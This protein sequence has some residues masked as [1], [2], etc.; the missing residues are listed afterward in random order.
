MRLRSLFLALWCLLFTSAL[1][2]A[3]PFPEATQLNDTEF[4]VG[5]SVLRTARYQS[6]FIFLEP[7]SVPPGAPRVPNES[8]GTEVQFPTQAGDSLNFNLLGA[9][10]RVEVFDAEGRR[11]T[12]VIFDDPD[13]FQN[14]LAFV[15]EQSG[16]YT[17]VFSLIEEEQREP[18]FGFVVIDTNSVQEDQVDRNTPQ[19]A[20]RVENF[21]EFSDRTRAVQVS[22]SVG[23][24]RSTFLNLNDLDE[25]G[26]FDL[27]TLDWQLNERFDVLASNAIPHIE[28]TLDTSEVR[29]LSFEVP[30]GSDRVIVDIDSFGETVSPLV[31]LQPN[32]SEGLPLVALS[33]NRNEDL[34]ESE[35]RE[36]D[37][38]IDSADPVV[39]L[40][41]SSDLVPNSGFIVEPGRYVID[42]QAPGS[43]GESASSSFISVSVSVDGHETSN[44]PE[45]LADVYSFDL[46]SDESATLLL[47]S[48][49]E[50]RLI[51]EEGNTLVEAVPSE[52]SEQELTIAP[53]SRNRRIFVELR[54]D[55][56]DFY[57]LD[58]LLSSDEPRYQGPR[59]SLAKVSGASPSYRERSFVLR[60]RYAD[61]PGLRRFSYQ[62]GALAGAP[63]A[64]DLGKGVDGIVTAR[65]TDALGNR[66]ANERSFRQRRDLQL[67]FTPETTGVYTL[68]VDLSE[69][70]GATDELVIAGAVSSAVEP[71]EFLQRGSSDVE[72]SIDLNNQFRPLTDRSSTLSVRG[73]IGLPTAPPIEREA[74]DAI[75]LAQFI[76][77]TQFSRQFN[78]EIRDS[79]SVPHVTI[80]GT[81]DGSRDYFSFNVP[82]GGARLIIDVDASEGFDPIVRV[83]DPDRRLIFT[84]TRTTFNDAEA[85]VSDFDHPF[86][87]RTLVQRGVYT[88]EVANDAFFDGDDIPDGASYR[89][90]ISVSGVRSTGSADD[91]SDVYAVDLETGDLLN[92]YIDSG[93]AD[94]TF[95]D[96][97]GVQLMSQDFENTGSNLRGKGLER[98]TQSG[99]YYVKVTSPQGTR[100][101]LL[102]LQD[103]RISEVDSQALNGKI[104]VNETLLTTAPPASAG[105]VNAYTLE[106]SAGQSVEVE[107]FAERSGTVQFEL[108]GNDGTLISGRDTTFGG[109]EFI[110]LSPVE[111]T[112]YQLSI[113]SCDRDAITTVIETRLAPLPF[114]LIGLDRLRTPFEDETIQLSVPGL[115]EADLAGLTLTI[116][117]DGTE[118]LVVPATLEPI[119][120]RFL[121]GGT[122]EVSV[123]LEGSRLFA[124]SERTFQV[125]VLPL[126][127]LT[128]LISSVTEGDGSS[129]RFRIQRQGNLQE[130]L[131]VVYSASDLIGNCEIEFSLSSPT[132]DGRFSVTIPAGQEQVT[133][134]WRPCSDDL[135]TP[136]GN[137][138]TLT[139]EESPSYAL[140]ATQQL[141]FTILEDD[142]SP[143]AAD[144][145]YTVLQGETLRVDLVEDG[146]LN[147]A[148]DQD[149]SG[150]D[151]FLS[152]FSNRDEQRLRL[153]NDVAEIFVDA[154]GTF[155]FLPND[156]AFTGEI[157]FPYSVSDGTNTSAIRMVT[158]EV[159]P[160]ALLGFTFEGPP[161]PVIK[162]G[163]LHRIGTGSLDVLEGSTPGPVLLVAEVE[164][165]PRYRYELIG[166]GITKVSDNV[167]R[168]DT[169]ESD[170]F[171][172]LAA[173][174]PG[175]DRLR[176]LLPTTFSI[177][178]L[179]GETLATVRED[180][181]LRSGRIVE[182]ITP[183]SVQTVPSDLA[184]DPQTGLITQRLVVRNT[185]RS[186]LN[187]VTITLSGLPD[188]VELVEGSLPVFR[189]SPQ[190]T[191]ELLVQFR[192][193]TR[194]LDFSPDYSVG[195]SN[196]VFAAP[197]GN[198]SGADA[199]AIYPL[200]GDRML[201]EWRV[202]PGQSYQVEYSDNLNDWLISPGILR[203]S[204][205]SLQWIDHG[206]PV[207]RS[208]P[209]Q[210]ATRIYRLRTTAP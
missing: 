175:E 14:T 174:E 68:S 207:T 103:A 188:G 138:V 160:A 107:I 117:V 153:P 82:S 88:I 168:I 115:S 152:Q 35:F 75:G 202:I 190:E 200:D 90:H 94:L 23:Q 126:V 149:T 157:R 111:D 141:D 74:N 38:F 143:V 58:L 192:S 27:E 104:D 112:V 46:A 37:P 73:L 61:L 69:L 81:G 161:V 34:P 203:P 97:N 148:V 62:F 179:P 76:S 177:E 2:T 101:E 127:S 51:D 17:V 151:L 102:L 57:I 182:I 130:P 80:E 147:G 1:L 78:D 83:Y 132:A 185:S 5:D 24:R 171:S 39:Q 110:T 172:I 193:T 167:F 49:V 165:P 77:P 19:L 183:S 142:F 178:E 123:R 210:Q 15:T 3:N 113:Q 137:T 79:S 84:D 118:A 124:D 93:E 109:G 194:S 11:L 116:S 131:Q 43:G 204:N 180:R 133:L 36:E 197:F 198:G 155:S 176:Q 99:R 40:G 60:Q 134:L 10:C 7:A 145:S 86:A 29:F 169:R 205:T 20:Q 33:R 108:T 144:Q 135:A 164:Q 136:S 129:L 158:V 128:P 16:F 55:F 67:E 114:D 98:V 100:Y 66:V 48:D 65:V 18:G 187:S 64:F 170:Q 54:A 91:L 162:D 166:P 156:P 173:V 189:L 50:L 208:R 89:M 154:R 106:V 184:L 53:V 201:V 30:E 47:D 139:L 31:L 125:S 56:Q 70:D 9:Q 44:N 72:R 150:R 95:L 32:R 121:T 59:A 21:S 71:P 87:D 52:V 12:S 159:T 196:E 96:A 4:F 191:L 41:P 199:L 6:D 26:G 181:V 28:V 195:L 140:Q 146:L 105:A 42:L 85:V 45:E 22:G 122:Q 163:D 8:S 120:V 209:S 25:N 206:P 119:P 63:V 13:V 186:L 92:A